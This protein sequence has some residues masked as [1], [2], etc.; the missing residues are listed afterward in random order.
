MLNFHSQFL[1]YQTNVIWCCD[2]NPAELDDW[3]GDLNPQSKVVIKDAYA[4][5]SLK[6]AAVGDSFQFERLGMF[7]KSC[8]LHPG[9]SPL[10]KL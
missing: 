9:P 3:L 8:H 6:D 5:P 1:F 7:L 10:P 4:V 2:Q